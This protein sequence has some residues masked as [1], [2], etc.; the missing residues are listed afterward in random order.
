MNRPVVTAATAHNTW[1]AMIT[2]WVRTPESL[3]ASSSPPTAYRRF[4][5]RL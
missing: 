1:A 5:N 2:R 4:P 3:A